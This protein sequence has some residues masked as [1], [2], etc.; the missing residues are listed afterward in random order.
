MF[1]E[2]KSTTI[3]FGKPNCQL[4]QQIQIKMDNR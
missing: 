3:M 1:P 2:K 4:K